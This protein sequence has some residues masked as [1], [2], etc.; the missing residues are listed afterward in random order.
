MTT[1]KSKFAGTILGLAVGDAL[2]YPMEFMSLA[3]IK[4]KY[5]ND[6]LTELSPVAVPGVGA[7]YSDDT[8]MSV[9][10]ADALIE[11]AG[12]DY[13]IGSIMNNIKREFIKWMNS[14]ENNRAPGMTCMAGCR[15]MMMGKHWSKSGN[16]DSKGCGAAMRSA[17]IGLVYHDDLE[18]LGETA[19][20]AS[21]CTHAHPDG[22]ASGIATAYLTQ[23][24]LHN[25]NP[26]LYTKSLIKFT[27]KMEEKY[28]FN[29]RGFREKMLEIEE[30]EGKDIE[31]DISTLG[32][33][34]VG[35]EAVAIALYCFLK[36]PDDFRK[37]VI[38]AANH[39]G[40]TDSTACIAGAIS[41]AYNGIE[42]IPG[43]WIL[44]LE[45][46]EELENLAHKLFEVKC[47][48]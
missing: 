31:K 1:L 17:P 23:M 18:K 22:I 8:Q 29:S 41:G 44:N 39:D 30:L 28:G 46:H 11:I 16:P 7:L 12:Q 2:G 9:A 35:D 4:K 3:Q 13:D 34:F 5:G 15:A 26:E 19:Y 43:D 40:D 36:S 48:S 25:Y 42:A 33:G 24:A 32:Q 20:A 45:K 6:G 14:P 27:K 38:M 47:I 10:I 21:I 37:T